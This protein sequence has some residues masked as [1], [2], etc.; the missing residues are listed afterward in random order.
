MAEM[1]LLKASYTGSLGNTTGAKWKNKAVIKAKIWSKAPPTASQTASVRAFECLNRLA[2][3]IAKVGFKQ[4]PLSAKKMLP[5]NAVAQW[6]KPTIKNKLWEPQNISEV[7]PYSN[8]IKFEFLIIDKATSTGLV[9]LKYES[10]PQELLGSLLFIAVFRSNGHIADCRVVPMFTEEYT[11]QLPEPI[12]GIYSAIGF[13][14]TPI[15]KTNKISNFIYK[16]TQGMKYS[17]EEQVTGD[18]WLDG[19]IIYKKIIEVYPKDLEKGTSRNIVLDMDPNFEIISADTIQIRIDGSGGPTLGQIDRV[20]ISSGDLQSFIIGIRHVAQFNQFYIKI[21]ITDEADVWST[22][23]GA[24]IRM[25]I[26]YTKTN[27]QPLI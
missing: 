7:I 8:L 27:E 19:R 17:T 25:A 13:L 22:P 16:E 5:H 1:D 18:L 26:S 3:A 20:D 15:D 2:S 12:F 24:R 14:S 21:A 4:L 6:L 23:F 10:Q 11:F 9:R